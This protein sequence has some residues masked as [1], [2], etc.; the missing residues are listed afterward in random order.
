MGAELFILLEREIPGF[1]PYVNGSYVSRADE[2]LT[3]LAIELGVT[4]LMEFFSA[5]PA[6]LMDFVEDEAELGDLELP[7]ETWF[8]AE[9]GLKTV[10]T[11]LEKLAERPE[12]IGDAA[13]VA[14][15]LREFRSVLLRA[16]SEG[17]R[18]HL[19]VDF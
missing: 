11:L 18:W 15:D 14:S 16:K 12:R 2:Q 13:E 8:E 10:E 17:V 1:D 3:Q 9:D 4:P 6:E 7:E 19:S 5:A